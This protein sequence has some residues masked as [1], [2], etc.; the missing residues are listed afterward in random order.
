VLGG[1]EDG[2][3]GVGP[4]VLAPEQHLLVRVLSLQSGVFMWL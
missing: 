2:E 3:A 4:Y 1:N